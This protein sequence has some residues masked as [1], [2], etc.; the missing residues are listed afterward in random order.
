[1]TT[2]IYRAMKK[3]ASALHLLLFGKDFL[4]KKQ[5][6]HYLISQSTDNYCSKHLT[7]IFI[8]EMQTVFPVS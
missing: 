2:N 1:M 4:K 8:A 6:V 5:L 7:A 3:W